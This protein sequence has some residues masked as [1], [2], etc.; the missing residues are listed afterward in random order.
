MGQ[1]F[2]HLGLL[3]TPSMHYLLVA[4]LQ[5]QDFYVLTAR[6]FNAPNRPNAGLSALYISIIADCPRNLGGQR[7]LALLPL[8]RKK[9]SSERYSDWSKAA[10]HG[11][12]QKQNLNTSP[13]DIQIGDYPVL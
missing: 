13:S 11:K 2:A 8:Q 5:E 1:A 10:Q 7:S 3:K 12:Q 4:F 6:L 9:G